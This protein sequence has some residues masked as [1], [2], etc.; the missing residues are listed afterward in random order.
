MNRGQELARAA[1]EKYGQPAFATS[2][3]EFH[4]AVGN[5]HVQL[6]ML[7]EAGLR[8]VMLRHAQELR[9]QGQILHSRNILR[10]AGIRFGNSKRKKQ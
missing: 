3:I 1:V 4:S 5:E 10:E 6:H 8:E 9:R 7:R 2:M